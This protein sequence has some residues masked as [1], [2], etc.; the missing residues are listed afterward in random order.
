MSKTRLGRYMLVEDKMTLRPIG[1]SEAVPFLSKWHYSPIMPKLTKIRL[2]YF[3]GNELVGVMTFGWGTRPLHTIRKLFSDLSSKDYYEIGKMAMHDKMPR[4]SESKMISVAIQWLK[5]NT[6]IKYLFTWAD[7]M[8]GKVGYVY[9]AANFLYGGYSETDT[10]VTNQNERVHPRTISGVIENKTGAKI[11]A[12]PTPEQCVEL[13]LTRVKGY[14]FKYI[15]PLNK[16][17]RKFLKTSTVEW[18]TNYP[19][20]KDLAW[21]IKRPTDVEWKKIYDLPFKISKDASFQNSSIY[22][23]LF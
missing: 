2:G 16:K 11:G 22:G 5:K 15:Y 8:V 12:R 17:Y 18:T 19:K 7:G 9:Q 13:D 14:Q 4:N 21:K 10:Y 1:L 23:N 20:E 3:D 6:D